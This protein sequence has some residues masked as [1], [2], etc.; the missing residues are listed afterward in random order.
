[1]IEKTLCRLS[2]SLAKFRIDIV[3]FIC[4]EQPTEI[5][6]VQLRCLHN[7]DD[8]RLGS[9]SRNIGGR[10]SFLGAGVISFSY[11]H[12]RTARGLMLH[13]WE[14]LLSKG[15]YQCEILF[16]NGTVL[17][18][19]LVFYP[20]VLPRTAIE[21]VLITCPSFLGTRWTERWSENH[22]SDSRK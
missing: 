19:Y 4:I 2:R 9:D 18:M 10:Y 14:I 17:L 21:D 16:P 20:F 12:A 3:I 6:Y 7:H 5:A 22:L 15:P 8:Y 13:S 11:V 1:M